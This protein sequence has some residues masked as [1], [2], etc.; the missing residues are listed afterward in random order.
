MNKLPRDARLSR[1]S[2]LATV[3]AYGRHQGGHL[4]G[5][6]FE[7]HLLDEHGR[8]AP[9]F[10]P[11]GVQ[12]LLEQLVVRGWRPHREGPYPIA[13]ELGGA[14]VTLEPGG[15]FELSDRPFET[16]AEVRDSA[17]A[18]SRLIEEI[19]APTPYRQ[20]A[21]GFTPVARIA[22]IP[23]VP[24]GRYVQMRQHMAASGKLGHHMMKGTAATQASFD[25]STEA[26]AAR[27][28]RIGSLLAPLI[29]GMFANSPFT[30]GRPN[31]FKSFRGVIWTETDP[32]RTGFPLAADDF[33]WE[34]WVD[35]LLEV[36]MMFIK[37]G[38]VW[39]SGRGATFRQWMTDGIEGTFPDADAWELHMTSVFPEVRI[40]RQIEVRSADCVALPMATAFTAL[41]KGLF[42][43]PAASR[44]AL[45]LSRRFSRYGTKRERFLVAS[46]TG[47]GGTVGGQRLASWAEELVDIARV[48]LHNCTPGD[49]PLLDPLLDHVEHGECPAD[50][51]LA[52]SRRDDFD[53]RAAAS[54]F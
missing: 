22:D 40:K 7:R 28:L 41:I 3:H 16:V 17:T 11:Y 39:Q 38:G 21:L 6:E 4:V 10:G 44:G 13:L 36:P 19:L 52:A 49:V 34:G 45:A 29:T 43:C 50:R 14:H 1:D 48:G 24:K 26:D 20:A 8:P 12:W 42:Y 18:F 37:L 5:A 54:M 31:G 47:L 15:Q 51:L 23:W 53:L 30:E 35:Y 27:K 33:T 9:Y 32:A 2:L 25:F 46:R